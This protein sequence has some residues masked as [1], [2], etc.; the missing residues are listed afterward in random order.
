MA[1]GSGH[2][3][4]RDSRE[5]KRVRRPYLGLIGEYLYIDVPRTKND[6]PRRVPLSVR[7][8]A[9]FKSSLR[10]ASAEAIASKSILPVETGRGIIHA[11]RDAAGEREF[12]DLRRHDLRHEGISLFR[13]SSG[14]VLCSLLRRCSGTMSRYLSER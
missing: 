12:P 4:D 5:T 13:R 14:L 8:V 9:S 10:K 1:R 3:I 2:H 7:A 6:R 11:F